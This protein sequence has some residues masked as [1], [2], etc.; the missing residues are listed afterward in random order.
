MINWVL[1]LQKG[2]EESTKTNKR[3][4][5]RDG[6]ARNNRVWLTI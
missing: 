6:E 5:E 1:L 3:K 2:R 4:R